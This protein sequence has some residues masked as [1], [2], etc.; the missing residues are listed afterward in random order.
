MEL[1]N[2]LKGYKTII[3]IIA[4]CAYMYVTDN[5]YI[6]YNDAIFYSLLALT[7]ISARLGMNSN[8]KK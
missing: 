3:G 6:E 1:L 8:K 5:G 2:K 7:G 4:T